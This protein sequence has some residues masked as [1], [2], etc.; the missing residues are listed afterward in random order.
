MK[1][2]YK[3]LTTCA[4]LATMASCQ[5]NET[6]VFNDATDAFAAFDISSVTVNEDAGSVSI[7]VTVASVNPVKVSVAYTTT[8]GTAKAGE[9]FN[10][11]D[12]SAVLQFN[13]TDRTMNLVVDIVNLAGEYTGDLSFNVSLVSAGDINLGANSSCTVKIADLDHPLASILGD[14][15]AK[16][17]SYFDGADAVWS[18]KFDKDPSDVTVV[19]IYGITA[20]TPTDGIYGNVV[21]D[22]ETGE[23][24]A[25][26]IPFGQSI[27]WNSSYDAMFVGF[28]EGGY[29][30][31]EGTVT[32]TR[33]DDGWVN[34][35]PDWGWGF[36]AYAKGN[37]SAIAG[38]A[39]AYMPG[40]TFTKK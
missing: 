11:S 4:A 1:K 5:L 29:Y 9:N 37:P 28:K 15:D 38:W 24:T 7:P 16:V 18:A 23:I 25:I 2:F 20:S 3:I 10:L 12:A 34:N 33:T 32:L 36:L 26:T 13:G 19:W 8:D 31:P 17:F 6:P 27:P 40:G 35:D 30:A 39:E 14:Y 21:T 22:S